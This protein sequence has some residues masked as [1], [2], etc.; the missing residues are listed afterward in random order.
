MFFTFPKL[1]QDSTIG[2]YDFNVTLYC[3][4]YYVHCA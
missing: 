1:I 3:I 4:T 2:A